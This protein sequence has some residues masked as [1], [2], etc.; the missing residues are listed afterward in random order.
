[1]HQI[2]NHKADLCS[3]SD[4]QP[5]EPA[6]ESFDVPRVSMEQM[7]DQTTKKIQQRP[8]PTTQ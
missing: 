6:D 7:V 4:D 1:M 8:P 2:F 3:Y 5:V